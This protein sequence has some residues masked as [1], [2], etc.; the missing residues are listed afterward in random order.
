MIGSHQRPAIRAPLL[1][2]PHFLKGMMSTWLT[3]EVSTMENQDFC[4]LK[5]V[6][7]WSSLQGRVRVRGGG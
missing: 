5:D 4:A 6:G 1:R 2:I 3:K 7:I